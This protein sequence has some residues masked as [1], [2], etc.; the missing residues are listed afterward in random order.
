[1]AQGPT[2]QWTSS[3]GIAPLNQ[4]THVALTFSSGLVSTYINGQLVQSVSGSGIIGDT[5]PDL[6]EFRIG[7]RPSSDQGFAGL[8]DEVAIFNR[9][10]TPNEVAGIY[11]AGSAG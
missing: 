6:N 7:S 8:V 4:W 2:W 9:A 11:T 10:I 5:Y 1:F 3:G